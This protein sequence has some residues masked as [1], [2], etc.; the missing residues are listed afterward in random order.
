MMRS[1][2]EFWLGLSTLCFVAATA[3]MAYLTPL[4]PPR[5]RAVPP[6]ELKVTDQ[7]GR[8]RVDWDKDHEL[9][10]SAGG[11]TLEVEDGGVTNRYPVE[12]N[13]LRAGGFD[14]IRKTQEVLLTLTLF[15]N[16]HPG[17]TAK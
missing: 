8:L 1:K 3:A 5:T 13:T 14:Y 10:R 15:Q 6:L 12:P 11:A 4:R 9:V 7:D 17:A 16:D 2:T